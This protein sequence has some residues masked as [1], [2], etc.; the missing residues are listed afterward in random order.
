[1]SEFENSRF[2]LTRIISQTHT[3]FRNK[4]TASVARTAMILVC[5]IEFPRQ[6]D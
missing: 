5:V 3:Y 6:T 2:I 1:L 4:N